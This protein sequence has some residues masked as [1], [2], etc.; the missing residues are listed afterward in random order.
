MRATTTYWFILDTL[1]LWK[2]KVAYPKG[3]EEK[4]IVSLQQT[5][6]TKKENKIKQQVPNNYKDYIHIVTKCCLY[7]TTVCLTVV[8]LFIQLTNFPGGC[9][10]IY[11][12]LWLLSVKL[13]FDGQ[14]SLTYIN[15]YLLLKICNLL[16]SRLPFTN[17]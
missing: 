10:L 1:M 2:I 5:K 17:L 6:K 16:Q 13:Q 7:L 15:K 9:L 4:D 11:L 3:R 8:F 14:I 12:S